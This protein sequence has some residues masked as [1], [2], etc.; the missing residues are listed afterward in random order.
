MCC[1][2]SSNW[3]EISHIFYT[4]SWCLWVKAWRKV[5][6]LLLL[7]SLGRLRIPCKTHCSW[8]WFQDFNPLGRILLEKQQLTGSPLLSSNYVNLYMQVLFFNSLLKTLNKITKCYCA[9]T[10]SHNGIKMDT[11]KLAPFKRRKIPTGQFHKLFFFF[12]LFKK[13]F[14][15]LST[16]VYPF[17]SAQYFL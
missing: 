1:L 16:P 3:W 2:C 14:L 15:I 7:N 13:L 5:L 9:S 8:V 11:Y 6:F 17:I 10:A 4:I 12:F